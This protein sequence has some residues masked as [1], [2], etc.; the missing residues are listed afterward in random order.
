MAVIKS[1]TMTKK[2]NFSCENEESLEKYEE[3][4]KNYNKKIDKEF[5]S[6]LTFE[7][8]YGMHIKTKIHE[9]NYLS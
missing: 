4:F 2:M 1:L 9:I 3:I 8:D 7:D 6:E 5:F